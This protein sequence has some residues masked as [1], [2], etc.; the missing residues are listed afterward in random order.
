MLIH[1]RANLKMF[2]FHRYLL[3]ILRNNLFLITNFINTIIIATKIL[4]NNFVSIC[5]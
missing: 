1:Y 4:N 3:A 2:Y 5:Y